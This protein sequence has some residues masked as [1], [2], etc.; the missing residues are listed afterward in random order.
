MS[1]I[2]IFLSELDEERARD[3][4]VLAR[5]RDAPADELRRTAADTVVGRRVQAFVA[6]GIVHIDGAGVCRVDAG[7]LAAFQRRRARRLFSIFAGIVLLILLP[8]A[9]MFVASNGR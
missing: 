9:L 3:A 6:R 8:L 5:L 1:A 2:K 7:R 4:A